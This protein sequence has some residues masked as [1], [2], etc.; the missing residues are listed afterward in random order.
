MADEFAIMTQN[1]KGQVK[2]RLGNLLAQNTISHTNNVAVQKANTLTLS[3]GNNVPVNVSPPRNMDLIQEKLQG[4]TT[5]QV[6]RKDKELGILDL[7]I[8]NVAL[9]L[10]LLA[11]LCGTIYYWVWQTKDAHQINVSH[12]NDRNKTTNQYTSSLSRL[13]E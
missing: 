13:F 9:F 7:Q 8:S 6:F 11:L 4:R 12:V 10:V 5:N 1:F 3:I 2:G